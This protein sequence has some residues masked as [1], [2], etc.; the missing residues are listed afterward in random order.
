M[1]P[2]VR[3]D[4]KLADEAIHVAL[5]EIVAFRTA[6]EE[7]WDRLRNGDCFL[8]ITFLVRSLEIR[9]LLTLHDAQSVRG[10]L[11]CRAFIFIW[12]WPN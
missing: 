11:S 8:A 5:K 2:A 4:T 12:N 7:G 3:L 1:P 9:L 10:E 6:A